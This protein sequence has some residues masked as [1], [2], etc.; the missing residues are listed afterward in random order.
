MTPNQIKRIV[1]ET[2]RIGWASAPVVMDDGDGDGTVDRDERKV[3]V[4]LGGTRQTPQG[5]PRD[6]NALL[7]FATRGRK[8]VSNETV[9]AH[10]RG[11]VGVEREET[12]PRDRRTVLGCVPRPRQSKPLSVDSILAT[13]SYPFGGHGRPSE[14]ST[15]WRAW[16]GRAGRPARAG[17]LVGALG[18]GRW[19]LNHH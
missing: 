4:A 7:W 9:D 5:I 2:V 19:G 3:L 1:P 18:Q 16:W 17:G 10:C 11:S 13:Y 8:P 14:H 15:G 6:A 12:G